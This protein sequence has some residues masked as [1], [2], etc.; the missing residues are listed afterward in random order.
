M[1][2]NYCF[3]DCGFIVS[4]GWQPTPSSIVA[5]KKRFNRFSK[6]R[7]SCNDVIE[8]IQQY[9]VVWLV[10]LCLSV[11]SVPGHPDG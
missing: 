11:Y 5:V 3:Y 8:N 1:E 4:T 2:S 10:I 7:K 9:M 6:K